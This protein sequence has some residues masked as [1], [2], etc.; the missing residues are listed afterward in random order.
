MFAL[1]RIGAAAAGTA[2]GYLSFKQSD[3]EDSVPSVAL[4]TAETTFVAAAAGS[5]FPAAGILAALSVPVTY[6]AVKARN[7]PPAAPADNKPEI[8]VV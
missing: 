6:A 1:R 5:I 4:K 8:P 2:F 3:R 7:T